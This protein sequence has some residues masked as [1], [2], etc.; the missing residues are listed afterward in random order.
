MMRTT[1]FLLALVAGPALALP[2]RAQTTEHT[3]YVSVLDKSGR[4]VG[5]LD[6]ADFV[7]T[8]DGRRREVLR[9]GRTS[10][11]LD[12]AVIVDNSFAAEANI[13]DLRKA[14]TAFVTKMADQQAN[15]ALVGMADRATVLMDYT[16]SLADMQKGVGRIF[17]QPGSGM[18]F[19]DTVTQT[20]NGLAKRANPRRA[21]LVITGEGTDFSNAPYQKTLDVLRTGGT[22]FHVIRLTNRGGATISDNNARDRALVI[23]EGPKVSGGRTQDVLS[24]MGYADALA[25]VA[26]DFANTY[27][28]VFA[29][30]GVLVPP[31]DFEVSVTRDGLSARGTLVRTASAGATK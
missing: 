14:L 13:L 31:K 20:V 7:V 19:Q 28:V 16:S 29:R 12:L 2:A 1:V 8:E 5:G 10:D 4:P 27:K 3:A 24:S 30:P 18:V 22:A 23:D 26:E 21:A 11:P 15:V 6:V 25:R 17:A 9:A